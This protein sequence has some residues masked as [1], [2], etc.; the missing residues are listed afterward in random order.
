MRWSWQWSWLAS[1][2]L[3]LACAPLSEPQPLD[4]GARDTGRTDHIAPADT[5]W[6]DIVQDRLGREAGAPDAA[7]DAGESDR[8]PP[9][10]ATPGP[11]ATGDATLV[12]D[13]TGDATPGPD[14]TGD[15]TPGP[16][17]NRPRYVLGSDS[18]I[19]SDSDQA[20]TQALDMIVS[21]SNELIACFGSW[22]ADTWNS[23]CRSIGTGS[24]DHGTGGHETA[25]SGVAKGP[26]GVL[27]AFEP[28]GDR[29]RG[30]PA[31][32]GRGIVMADGM[33]Y[34]Q[35]VSVGGGFAVAAA[36]SVSGL[37]ADVFVGEEHGGGAWSSLGTQ[38]VGIPLRQTYVAPYHLIFRSGY[39]TGGSPGLVRVSADRQLS[40][41]A[42]S[43]LP[44]CE[45]ISTAEQ[46]PRVGLVAGTYS[47]VIPWR[48]GNC[49]HIG[50][51]DPETGVTSNWIPISPGADVIDI[52]ALDEN[53]TF[54]VAT[55]FP[56]R[57]RLYS[58]AF[59]LIDERVF[60]VDHV[61][62]LA[63]WNGALHIGISG[64]AGRAEIRAVELIADR[65][66]PTAP[67][68]VQANATGASMVRLTWQAASDDTGV[69]G[70]QIWRDG[71]RAGTSLTTEFLDSGLT[72]NTS[73]SYRVA[74]FDA[75]QN[76][77]PLSAPVSV[78]TGSCDS[79]LLLEAEAFTA[80]HDTTAGNSGHTCSSTVNPDVDLEPCTEGGCSIGWMNNG[81][82]LEW[83][84]PAMCAG[85][86]T[87]RL[88]VA[89]PT[90]TA[91]LGLALD[92][93]PAG[94]VAVP[95]SGGWQTWTTAIGPSITWSSGPHVLRLTVESEGFNLNWVQIGEP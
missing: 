90:G 7:S 52:L 40:E 78:V 14:A 46:V 85:Q 28:N 48:G 13:A 36:A 54:A 35:A 11:D 24:A 41:V 31:L 92:G 91:R 94:S 33:H 6:H 66:P 8:R 26:A 81:E 87:I 67:T 37:A 49:A 53:G 63:V 93:Q 88:R 18:V 71:V 16:D 73:Y 77:S 74:A 23:Y 20:I 17:A 30:G 58:A 27:Y 65:A 29:N 60:A 68:L 83:N 95:N 4:A 25:G 62:G 57:L 82:W 69:R 59:E 1:S 50:L 89:S 19:Y 47:G 72:A 80:A 12:P 34:W 76:S 15:A 43:S 38:G 39:T 75:V 56:A 9:V 10:D 5:A 70:Y 22:S 32:W 79:F 2:L 84:L 3:A 21:D 51:L 55:N 44:G 61:G 86:S 64:G 45:G 42:Y